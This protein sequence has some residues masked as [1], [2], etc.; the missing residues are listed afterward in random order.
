ML[1]IVVMLFMFHSV[2]GKI[3]YVAEIRVSIVCLKGASL[4]RSYVANKTRDNL[5]LNSLWYIINL[6]QLIIETFLINYNLL[7][8]A[9]STS[10]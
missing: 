3:N 5:I 10:L 6:A 1:S 4:R 2:V 9:Y 7:I 8:T